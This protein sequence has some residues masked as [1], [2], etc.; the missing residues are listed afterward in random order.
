M[1]AQADKIDAK[2]F[3]YSFN[4]FMVVLL[5]INLYYKPVLANIILE[6]FWC[7]ISLYGLYNWKKRQKILICG[8]SFAADWTIK[9]KTSGWVNFLKDTDIIAQAGVGE[10]KIL[11]QLQSCKLEL[12]THIIISHT[13]FL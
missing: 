12:Y 4:N 1:V 13:S 8:D 3:W 6:V 5:F 7:F 10:Y 11:K 2:G 9:T